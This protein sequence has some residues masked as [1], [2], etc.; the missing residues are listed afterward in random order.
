MFPQSY[1]QPMKRIEWID[2]AK[3]F[4]M[5]CV[6]FGHIEVFSMGNYT[7]FFHRFQFLFC[8]PLFF[9]L[10]GMVAKPQH[11]L[12]ESYQCL[13][14]KFLQ[15]MI[16]FVATGSLY[17][18]VCCPKSPWWYLFWYPEGVGHMGYWF[19]LVMFEIYLLF[20]IVQIITNWLNRFIRIKESFILVS[21]F[22]WIVLLIILLGGHYRVYPKEPW[23]TAI[24]FHRIYNYF[25][26][27]I[28]GHWLMQHREMMHRIFTVEA[29]TLATTIFVPLY[30]YR[31]RFD[32]YPLP[33]NW[34]LAALAIFAIIYLLRSYAC[35]PPSE[36]GSNIL[37]K[38]LTFVG[39]HT[40]EIYVLHY[41]FI[42]KEMRWLNDV[43]APNG[44]ADRNILLEL[45]ICSALAI[46][47]IFATLACAWIVR[48]NKLFARIFLGTT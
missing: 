2:I 30:I 6:V 45:L 35:T 46:S 33:L 29:F 8:M 26:F 48:K 11:T 16:P 39:R 10:S 27:F 24:S 32:Y 40:L 14:K 23:Q 20:T 13:K 36:Q 15:L 34:L 22:F 37:Q 42:P 7:G 38:A 1:H 31:D 44:I 47:I 12:K 28:M 5:F 4:A 25:P 41:F 18:Y 19:L 43:I 21:F 17:V 9:F 3:A